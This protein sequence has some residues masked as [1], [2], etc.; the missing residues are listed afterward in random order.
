MKKNKCTQCNLS[1]MCD[2]FCRD[3]INNISGRLILG[4]RNYYGN[5]VRT[6][7]SCLCGCPFAHLI[8]S[9]LRMAMLSFMKEKKI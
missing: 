3:M 9:T 4:P 7:K 1:H 6:E 8:E 5:S 2:V